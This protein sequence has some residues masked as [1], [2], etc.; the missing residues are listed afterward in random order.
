MEVKYACN[1]GFEGSVT[2]LCGADG[3]YTVAGLCGASP[4]VERRRLYRSV[5]GLTAAIAVENFVAFALLGLFCWRT[6]CALARSRWWRC[7]EGAGDAEMVR[8]S[9]LNFPLNEG[10]QDPAHVAR[11]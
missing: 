7:R 9:V 10:Q 6:R 11:N 8:G 1:L 5:Q 2:A 4:N 3:N